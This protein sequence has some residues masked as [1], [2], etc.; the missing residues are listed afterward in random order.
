MF[1]FKNRNLLI[2]L[3]LISSM[4]FSQPD[5]QFYLEQIK[6]VATALPQLLR[7]ACQI[8]NETQASLIKSTPPT[9][10]K[11]LDLQLNRLPLLKRGSLA[12]Q[13]TIGEALNQVTTNLYL[14]CSN[15]QIIT[16]VKMKSESTKRPD[17]QKDYILT[18]NLQ[19]SYDE[20]RSL[21]ISLH[22]SKSFFYLPKK[23]NPSDFLNP[24]DHDLTTEQLASRQNILKALAISPV[25][26]ADVLLKVQIPVDSLVQ[27]LNADCDFA[28]KSVTAEYSSQDYARTAALIWSEPDK[29]ILSLDR[30]SVDAKNPEECHRIKL[31]DYLNSIEQVTAGRLAPKV[32]SVRTSQ[33]R[34][35][36]NGE[37]YLCEPIDGFRPDLFEN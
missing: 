9:D 36:E 11:Q 13:M 21:T 14:D 6:P 15:G 35:S 23:S 2:A 22:G 4:A 7:R 16:Y 8:K 10:L 37:S 12:Q 26:E 20:N 28:V 19:L 1:Q 5:A 27:N 31:N 33:C 17:L 18:N 29:K 25:L 34:Y 3:N 24:E 30:F 32:E